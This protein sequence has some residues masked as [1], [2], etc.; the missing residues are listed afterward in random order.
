MHNTDVKQRGGGA[1]RCLITTAVAVAV[2]GT[3]TTLNIG[4]VKIL[5]SKDKGA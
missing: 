4:I 5:C 1:V 3:V 2:S